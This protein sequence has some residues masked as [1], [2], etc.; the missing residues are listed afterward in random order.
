MDRLAVNFFHS[1]CESR[2]AYLI[3]LFTWRALFAGPFWVRRI[4]LDVRDMLATLTWSAPAELAR[5][6]IS[7]LQAVDFSI[8]SLNC[9]RGPA[10]LKLEGQW[11]PEQAG[12][13]PRKLVA[14]WPA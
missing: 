12:G 7:Q 13:G 1:A 2:S 5:S 10:P 9:S 11:R 4:W 3:T 6:S 8:D 14:R